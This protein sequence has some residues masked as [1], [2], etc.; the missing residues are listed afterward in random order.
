MSAVRAQL[1]RLVFGMRTLLGLGRRGYFIPYRYA[2]TSPQPGSLPAYGALERL[3]DNAGPEMRGWLARIAA[4]LP[5]LQEIGQ[6]AKPPQPR[7]DQSWYPGLDAAVAYTLVRESSPRRILEVGSGHSTRFLARAVADGGLDCKVTAIDPAPRADLGNL[8]VELMRMTLQEAGV[9]P[10]AQLQGGDLLLVDSSHI[11]MPGSDVDFLL[12]R[13][14]PDLPVG[15][16][17]AFHDIFLPDDYPASWSWRGYNEQQGVM[18]L[19]QGGSWQLMFSSHYAR[20]RLGAEVVECGVDSLA[21]PREAH[22]SVLWMQRVSRE[23][24]VG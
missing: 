3:F 9:A 23:Y 10:F 22:E 11:L 14:L 24:D 2:Q 5:A 1:R 18:G 15:I 8:P 16:R 12:G 19:L 21:R 17:V 13:V 6:K 4:Q 20:S 7:W